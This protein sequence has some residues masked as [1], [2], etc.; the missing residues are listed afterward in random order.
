MKSCLDA[1]E[2]GLS[3]LLQSGLDTGAALSAEKFARLSGECERCGLHTGARL[4]EQIADQL[5]RRGRMMEK[6]DGQ[7]MDTI[8]CAG[9]YIRLCLE[10]WQEE[11]I[12]RAWQEHQEK[13]GDLT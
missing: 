12:L 1:M 8:S 3:D 4:M 7:L 9:H 2:A 5:R 10:K 6:E 13:G 11:C